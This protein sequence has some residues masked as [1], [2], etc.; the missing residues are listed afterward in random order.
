[1]VLL[2]AINNKYST[3][4]CNMSFTDGPETAGGDG[5][6]GPRTPLKTVD[7]ELTSLPGKQ[8]GVPRRFGPFTVGVAS[9][10]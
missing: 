6:H 5:V 7:R 4:V 9:M 1:M 3:G 8:Y 2:Y 10:C